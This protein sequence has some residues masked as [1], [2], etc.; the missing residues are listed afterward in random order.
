MALCYSEQKQLT[1]HRFFGYINPCD[2][3]NSIVKK[4][5][6]EDIIRKWRVKL[7]DL[8]GCKK[9]YPI[10]VQTVA[11]KLISCLL[12]QARLPTVAEGNTLGRI[13]RWGVLC[14][15]NVIFDFTIDTVF[16]HLYNLVCINIYFKI[17]ELLLQCVLLRSLIC[18]LF[19]NGFFPN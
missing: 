14:V 3:A 15:L 9:T 19:C 10:V 8:Y 18:V 7:C 17:A 4:I 12:S 16:H 2:V 11:Y 5:A 6:T 1:T 13:F